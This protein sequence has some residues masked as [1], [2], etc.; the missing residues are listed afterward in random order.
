VGAHQHAEVLARLAGADRDHVPPYRPARSRPPP[1]PRRAPR[2]PHRPS[3]RRRRTTRARPRGGTGTTS[4]RSHGYASWRSPRVARLGVT[5]AAAPR[6]ASGTRWRSA[7]APG[8]TCSGRCRYARSCTVMTY[9]IR[10]GRGATKFVMCHSRAGL[11]AVSTTVEP[12]GTVRCHR[13]A[14]HRATTAATG[15]RGVAGPAG[16]P[17]QRHRDQAE[18]GRPGVGG[19]RRDQVPT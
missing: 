10:R 5:T 19:Q 11:R 17:A 15:R 2:R 13:R 8:V 7:T 18:R 12:R 9:G 4:A 3:R 1:R 14:R 6:S 16:A